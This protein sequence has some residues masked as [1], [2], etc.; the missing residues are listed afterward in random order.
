M[1]T[2]AKAEVNFYG[3]DIGFQF[4]QTG[5]G[6]RSR[7]S[8][9]TKIHEATDEEKFKINKKW[10]EDR[11]AREYS[12][13]YRTTKKTSKRTTFIDTPDFKVWIGEAVWKFRGED[14]RKVRVF[15][16][17]VKDYMPNDWNS[18]E[19]IKEGDRK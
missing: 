4:S 15:G 11:E 19:E 14:G 13:K 17:Q 7:I 3:E 2:E 1:K 5:S 18:F 12:R 6:K 16:I 10:R 9:I 8:K